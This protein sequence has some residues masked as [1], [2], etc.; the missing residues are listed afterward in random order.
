M[1]TIGDDDWS[2]DNRS[3]ID[4]AWGFDGDWQQACRALWKKR[5]DPGD[6]FQI[7]KSLWLGWKWL[8]RR[9]E[10]LKSHI[11]RH[12][13]K[14]KEPKKQWRWNW[15]TASRPISRIGF[16][17]HSIE[18][19]DHW[20]LGASLSKDS[21]DSKAKRSG[22]SGVAPKKLWEANRSQ[23]SKF[24]D[25]TSA[26]PRWFWLAHS[27]VT[28]ANWNWVGLIRREVSGRKLRNDQQDL[29]SGSKRHA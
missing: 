9:W 14:K 20:W 17:E 4:E 23:E 27:S 22:S 16:E 7:F 26:Y 25:I 15:R 8:Q 13:N 3:P 28:W 1:S 5:E 24:N 21:F 10:I 6:W 2:F 18:S 11:P 19:I 29:D 12:R